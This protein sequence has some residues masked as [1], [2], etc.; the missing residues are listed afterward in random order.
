MTEADIAEGLLCDQVYNNQG[1]RWS[2]VAVLPDSSY[3]HS[4]HH[5]KRTL[6][7]AKEFIS[8]L[9]GRS[10]GSAPYFCSDCWFY[11]QA[12][13]YNY[14][15]YEQVPYKGRGRKPNPIQVVDPD[16]RYA[17]V[18]KKRDKKGRLEEVSTRI[19]LGDELKILELLQSA[20]RCKTINTVYVE[21]RNGKFRKD[22]ARL[23]RKTLCHSKKSMYHDAHI[24]FVAQV[25]N[26]TRPNHALKILINPSA[27]LFERKYQHRTPAM[28]HGLINK[29]L[30]IKELLSIRPKP[31]GVL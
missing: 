21:S 18:H 27:P 29:Q 20:Q 4:T 25:M 11:E 14:C 9:K 16:L 10:D 1:D 26:Y 8:D 2:F 22:D 31:I 3:I 24:D 23:I 28:A 15:T 19:V 12:L 30:N 5:S 17:Q 6:E 13:E 7:A